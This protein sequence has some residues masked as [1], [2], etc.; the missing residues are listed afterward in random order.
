LGN[1]RPNNNRTAGKRFDASWTALVA[2]ET[3]LLETCLSLAIPHGT[4]EAIQV[5]C[6]ELATNVIMHG[7]RDCTG[8]SQLWIEIA[9][10]LEGQS[11]IVTVCDNGAEFDTGK[12]NFDKGEQPTT[13]LEVG[14]L[15]LKLIRSMAEKVHYTRVSGVNRTTLDFPIEPGTG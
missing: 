4:A 6:E 13:R 12:I 2:A 11:A 1:P 15:G 9:I 8:D 14:G 7:A 5:C 3:W 10:R